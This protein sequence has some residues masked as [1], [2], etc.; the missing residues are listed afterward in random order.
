VLVL[1][2]LAVQGA[3]VGAL[4]AV[5]TLGF[6]LVYASSRTIHLA[7][8]AVVIFAAYIFYWS[9]V[10]LQLGTVLAILVTLAITGML[11]ALME[12]T[13]YRPLRSNAKNELSLVVVASL[14]LLILIQ[15]FIAIVFGTQHRLPNTGVG[16]FVITMGGVVF[17]Q[18]NM[19][20][21]AIALFVLGALYIWLERTQAGLH[22][23]ALASS[24]LM[25]TLVGLS[26]TRLYLISF[27]IAS[28]LTVPAGVL[29]FYSVGITP[30]GG[31]AMVLKAAVAT[32]IGGPDHLWFAAAAAFL[33]GVLE[34]VA[35][36]Q[37]PA[38]LNTSVSFAVLAVFLTVKSFR[39]VSIRSASA[40][41]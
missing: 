8:G 13:V 36:W 27:V 4:Y 18:D 9:D 38:S 20:R 21:I 25:A 23:R 19:M 1:F 41:T 34:G 22:L 3:A 33:L 6:A 32:I 5:I 10:T 16:G 17:T 14:G 40:R 35:L 28:M 11:G 15:S 7:H 29:L 24:N 30:Y 12:M 26:T 39:T 31:T 2:Q 37:I